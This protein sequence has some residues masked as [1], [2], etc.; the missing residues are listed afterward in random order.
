MAWVFLM[1]TIIV[2]GVF[3][4]LPMV[5]A[6]ALSLWDYFPNAPENQFVF[7][8]N[9]IRLL[10]DSAFWLSVR[11]SLLYLLCVPIIVVLSLGLALLVEPKIPGI[12]FFRACY[13]LPVVTMMVVVAF[14]WS[15]IFDTDNGLLN[16][17]LA[18]AGISEEGIGWL[19][20]E[21][22]A[23]WSVMAV[24]VWK[25]L[26]YYMVLFI[27]GLKAVPMELREAAR[28]DGA[29]SI[30]SFFNVTIPSL[31]PVISIASIIS[32]ISA[33]QVFEEIY[34]MTNG[35]VGTSTVVF[36]I[37]E[38]GFDMGNGGIDLGYASAMGV[39]LFAIIFSFTAISAR[40]M[41]SMYA[42]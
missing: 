19:T 40:K 2:M 33:L 34:M 13:Y 5:C 25:G 23:L 28:I 22:Y 41:D 10:H 3:Q 35:R 27:V 29:N 1:P 24:T 11:N 18:A 30:Q 39:V 8:D 7:L 21:R 42:K 20:N 4:F 37:Y 36:D 14:A 38:T 15:L 31:W 9:F 6:F 32:S 26:G 12:G 17:F 16:A